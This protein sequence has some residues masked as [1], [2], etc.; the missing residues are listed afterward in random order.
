MFAHAQAHLFVCVRVCVDPAHHPPPNTHTHAEITIFSISFY[1]VPYPLPSTKVGDP[2]LENPGSAPAVFC[3]C[4]L[5]KCYL[6]YL[7][8][9]RSYVRSQTYSQVFLCPTRKHSSRMH[10]AHFSDLGEGSPYIG[11]PVSLQRTPLDRDPLE[12]T[13]DQ[14]R[15]PSRRNTGPG[16]QT[17]SDIIQRPPSLPWTDNYENI[18]LPQTSFSGGNNILLLCPHCVCFTEMT[19]EGLFK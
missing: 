9:F 4:S 3:N 11:L 10:T 18:T 12:G 7:E 17:G 2:A 14:G 1:A 13:W 8:V 16:S 6:V 19:S 15:R 5:I